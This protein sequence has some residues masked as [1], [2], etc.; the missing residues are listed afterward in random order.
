MKVQSTTE[1]KNPGI[2]T[3]FI[4]LLMEIDAAEA[5][6]KQHELHAKVKVLFKDFPE[7]LREFESFL[8]PTQSVI[9]DPGGTAASSMHEYTVAQITFMQQLEVC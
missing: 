8:S 4:Q 2:Y 9:D 6:A 3:T 7:L 5:N 1:A